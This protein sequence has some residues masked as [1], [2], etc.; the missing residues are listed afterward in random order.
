MCPF[1][2]C[3]ALTIS[4]CSMA[5]DQTRYDPVPGSETWPTLKR[6]Q[7]STPSI[8]RVQKTYYCLYSQAEEH[9]VLL[10]DCQIDGNPNKP[11]FDDIWE[12]VVL[13]ASRTQTWE[14]QAGVTQSRQV[15]CIKEPFWYLLCSKI[16][17]F[18]L[19]FK[20][21]LILYFHYP[22]ASLSS[23]Q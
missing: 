6:N 9:K 1:S 14:V 17:L 4:F 5:Q 20:T 2:N 19:P 18:I 7:D 22:C 12:W 11:G 8:V 21:F 23:L 15:V 16:V 10:A 3:S 13:H